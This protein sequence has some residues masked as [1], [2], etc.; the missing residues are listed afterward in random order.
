MHR[1]GKENA[2]LTCTLQINPTENY[3]P[4]PPLELLLTGSTE[5]AAEATTTASEIQG[6]RTMR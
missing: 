6:T 1:M 5:S 4:V 2:V 3:S